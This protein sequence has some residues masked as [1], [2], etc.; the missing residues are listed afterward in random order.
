[1]N[2]ETKLTQAQVELICSTHG[3]PYSSH[4]R[5][6]TGFSHEVHRL[7]D[8]LVLKVF[9][10]TIPKV[11]NAELAMLGSD[12]AFPKPTLIAS[13]DGALIGRSYIIMSY[14]PGVPLGTVWHG[15]TDLQRECLIEAVSS[16]LRMINTL[17][18]DQLSGDSFTSWSDQLRSRGEALTKELLADQKISK[19]QADKVLHT[20]QADSKYLVT[21]KLYSVYWDIHF[22]NF[23]VNDKFE[24]QAI[25]DLENTERA[26][27]DYPLFVIYKQI[28]KPHKY[29]REDHEQ[30]AD[31]ADYE[32][33][34]SWYQKYYPEMFTFENQAKRINYYLLL[35]TLWLCKDWWQGKDVHEDLARYTAE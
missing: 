14:I 26:A 2:P 28:D 3:I 13:D 35:D 25:I 18:P 11:F 16:T 9:N 33:L 12:L 34:E 31:K 5:I 4:E 24:L 8:D 17:D 19:E 30:Y 6:T 29:L 27:I 22:D 10:A 21:D 7:N 15:A 20:L 32:K 23:I 1:M